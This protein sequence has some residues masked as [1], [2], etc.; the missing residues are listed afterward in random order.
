MQSP[1][2]IGRSEGKR[3]NPLIVRWVTRSIV[4]TFGDRLL[5]ERDHRCR[6]RR[7]L[8]LTSDQSVIGRHLVRTRPRSPNT[9]TDDECADDKEGEN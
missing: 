9:E 6:Q 2:L 7:G 3:G 4:D 5:L 8:L 1:L